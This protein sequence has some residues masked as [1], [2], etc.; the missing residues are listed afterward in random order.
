MCASVPPSSGKWYHSPMIP[1]IMGFL[2][3]LTP[4]FSHHQGRISPV[5]SSGFD[6]GQRLLSP[7]V[8]YGTYHTYVITH[9]IV[10]FRFVGEARV[11]LFNESS[12]LVGPYILYTVCPTL[13]QQQHSCIDTAP[14]KKRTTFPAQRCTAQHI[15]TTITYHTTTIAYYY[16][17]FYHSPCTL[18]L[19]NQS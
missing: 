5:R 3:R 6:G 12:N 7:Y 13:S 8:W 11:I 2:H 19:R 10:P 17:S 14:V 9:V 15:D 1:P 4:Q 16:Q 18:N